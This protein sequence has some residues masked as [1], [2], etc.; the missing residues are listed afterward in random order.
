MTGSDQYYIKRQKIGLILGPILFFTVFITPSPPGLDHAGWVTA[1]IALLMAVWWISEALPI[2]VIALIPLVLLPFLDV[3]PIGAASPPYANPLIFLFMGGFMI[4]IAMQSWNL[5]RRVALWIVNMVG[6]KPSSII[7]GFMI[8]SAFLS[9]WVSNTATALMMLPIGMSIIHLSRERAQNARERAD[10]N[11]FSIVLVLSIAYACNIGGLGTIIGTPPNALLVGFMSE[12]YG[13]EI[14]FAQWMILGVPLVI[15]SLPI[16]YFVLARLAFPITLNE[17]PGGN[18]II[19]EELA[20][21]GSLTVPEK[22]VAMIFSL[23]A[24]AWIFR[25]LIENIIPGISDAG[26]AMTAAIV[27]FI[28]PS[29]VKNEIF[30][31]NW[32]KAGKL[33]WG[34]LL[35]FGGGLS[36]ANAISTTGLAS[37]IG[38]SVAGLGGWPVIILLLIVV[39]MIIFL[40]EITSNT[41]TAAAFLP[42]L[43]SVAI[44]IDQNPLLFVLPA[45]L[46][47]SCAFMLPVATPPNA[48]VF[49]SGLFTVPEMARAGFILNLM[50]I[51]LLVVFTY[52]IAV[53]VLGIEFGQ[54]PNWVP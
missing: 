30:I 51:V 24:A 16:A 46:A 17:L 49:G 33:P 25:P 11:T 5:H 44:G 4:A 31:M 43:A 19:R 29:G 42:I 28:I 37:W 41:A 50:L 7:F 48:I 21:L 3:M 34:V 26:I 13:L 47:A 15:L 27:L 54:L 12:T 6:S 1:A 10:Q 8:A 36:L 38:Q 52:F 39:S 18:K 45:A 22:R 40:T 14:G 53:P 9:M 35:L 32:D 20:K 2:P 23:T